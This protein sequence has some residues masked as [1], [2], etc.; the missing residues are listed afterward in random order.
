MRIIDVVPSQSVWHL[1]LPKLLQITIPRKKTRILC[2]PF[3]EV[4]VKVHI[5]PHEELPD[6]VVELKPSV[7]EEEPSTLYDSDYLVFLMNDVTQ[8]KNIV[9]GVLYVKS[10]C[11][12]RLLPKYCAYF[13]IALPAPYQNELPEYGDSPVVYQDS[14]ST[15]CFFISD[16]IRANMTY[17]VLS[18]MTELRRVLPS[19]QEES[20][21]VSLQEESEPLSLQEVKNCLDE[22]MTRESGARMEYLSSICKFLRSSSSQYLKHVSLSLV[23]QDILRTH[24]NVVFVEEGWVVA[25]EPL[26]SGKDMESKLMGVFVWEENQNQNQNQN[27]KKKKN[28]R[29]GIWT[30]EYSVQ[31]DLNP[32]P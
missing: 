23:I 25:S 31:W 18:D 24:C 14:N 12:T 9:R 27:S 6:Y 3:F 20:S 28:A 19:K 17:L 8:Q 29:C 5:A 32:P 4:K 11:D 10:S 13:N 26:V 16:R 1:L 22:V 2:E 21:P 15:E 7:F 30:H